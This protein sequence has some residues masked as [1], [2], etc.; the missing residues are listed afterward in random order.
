MRNSYVH[1]KEM[2]SGAAGQ[3]SVNEVGGGSVMTGL[4]NGWKVVGMEIG[5]MNGVGWKSG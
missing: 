3:A 2:G 5:K 1:G 4:V